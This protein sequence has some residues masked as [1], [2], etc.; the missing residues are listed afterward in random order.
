MLPSMLYVR[1]RFVDDDF[2][3]PLILSVYLAL[4][5]EEDE[6]GEREASQ[7]KNFEKQPSN[8]TVEKMKPNS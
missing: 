8:L 6:D 7:N 1:R 2:F 5:V 3:M 4:C